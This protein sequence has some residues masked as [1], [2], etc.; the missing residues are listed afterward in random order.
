MRQAEL[1][2]KIAIVC[3][4][5]RGLGKAC[6]SELARQGASVVICART[7]ATL[8]TTAEEISSDTGA[9][10]LPVV[11]DVNRRDDLARL[12]ETTIAELSS[13]DILVVNVGHPQMGSFF[14]LDED[15]WQTGFEQ[16]LLSTVHLY[17]LALP[18]M[19]KQGWG[20]VVNIASQAIRVPNSTYLVSG[21]F[22]IAGAWLS[23]ALANEFGSDGITI[24]TICP[25]L[26]RTPLGE[27]IIDGVAARQN[28]SRAEAEAELARPM[29]IGRIGEPE[30][31]AGLV[32]FLC[33]EVAGHITGQTI[34]IDGGKTRG[35][36]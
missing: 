9:T 35:L 3:G 14:E 32:A 13:F 22:R 17:R 16:V 4:A 12:V 25:G 10:I 20:R 15:A 27:A 34:T 7:R 33:S 6:A 31:L 30:E 28:V 1:G 21:V 11:C 26:F 29:P 8:V 18:V 5:S 36:F 23:K 2:G 19:K 24:N